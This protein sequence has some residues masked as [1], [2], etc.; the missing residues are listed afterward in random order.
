MKPIKVSA[1]T[2][3][4]RQILTEIGIFARSESTKFGVTAISQKIN[5]LF[6]YFN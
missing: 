6:I 2:K 4:I 3:N 1:V 5:V